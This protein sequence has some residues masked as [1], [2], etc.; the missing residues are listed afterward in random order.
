MSCCL[1]DTYLT[2]KSGN[3]FQYKWWLNLIF[4]HAEYY[5]VFK[6][7]VENVFWIC[8]GNEQKSL[9]TYQN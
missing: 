3:K 9:Q 1:V 4:M 7:Q 2:T 6:I 5:Y 8:K